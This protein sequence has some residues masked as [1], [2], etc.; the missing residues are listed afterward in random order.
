MIFVLATNFTPIAK[1]Y[2][3]GSGIL[4]FI[5]YLVS[6]GLI[7]EVGKYLGFKTTKSKTKTEIFTNMIYV[8]LFFTIYEDLM[9]I[10]NATYS[11]NVSLHRALTPLHLFFNLIM[12][13][14]L[15][16]AHEA[17]QNN[18]KNKSIILEITAIAIP[19]IIHGLNDFLITQLKGATFYPLLFII[20]YI[21]LI[22]YLLKIKNEKTEEIQISKSDK[23][24]KIFKIF[25]VS[26]FSIL[27]LMSISNNTKI[28]T[29]KLIDNSIE[30]TVN[31]SREEVIDDII[32]NK[33]NYVI[34]NITLKNTTS[35]DFSF[36]NLS[37]YLI[38][39][40][41]INIPKSYNKIDINLE[42]PIKANDTVTGE[43]YFKTKY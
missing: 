25:L 31:S 9:Y 35:Q 40:T 12:A 4:P 2:E 23:L 34:V 33:Q 26:F 11:L 36:D 22:I 43:L 37:F 18:N 6:V 39:N 29:S 5:H 24:I 30:I 17:K 10:G 41:D 32:E 42:N 15:I 13:H 14:Y 38:D 19:I 7:E 8:S 20:S 27:P 3:N 21:P 1:L 28:N 16:K